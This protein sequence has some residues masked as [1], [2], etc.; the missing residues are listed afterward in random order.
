MGGVG[1]GPGK[2]L[3][4]WFPGE[5]QIEESACE[6]RRRL[7]RCIDAGSSRVQ[8]SFPDQYCLSSLEIIDINSEMDGVSR[9]VK[10]MDSRLS[11]FTWLASCISL[12]TPSACWFTSLTVPDSRIFL[13]FMN[14]PLVV[15][16]ILT[17]DIYSQFCGGG[18]QT[19][20]RFLSL[21]N[22]WYLLWKWIVFLWGEM[23][24]ILYE[25]K[26]LIIHILGSGLLLLLTVTTATNS[27]S[28]AIMFLRLYTCN[29]IL[30]INTKFLI[31]TI[32]IHFINV[33]CDSK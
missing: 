26:A 15:I 20:L 17:N 25:M 9:S 3:H 16:I 29:Y 6:C 28:H 33:R 18:D 12:V 5:Q 11:Y 23:N 7:H 8:R 19:A 27:V 22:D 14:I 32:N 4:L 13:S 2:R 21:F 10:F 24:K 31:N 30:L 1:V